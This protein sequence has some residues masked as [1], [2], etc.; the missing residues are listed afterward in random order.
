MATRRRRPC[1]H[2]KL[3]NK[4]RG[5]RCRKVSR[6]RRRRR[7]KHTEDE[8]VS[9][10]RRRRRSRKSK[11]CKARFPSSL[12]NLM[13]RSLKERKAFLKLKKK[14]TDLKT[15]LS[16]ETDAVKQAAINVELVK[17][18]LDVE[19]VSKKLTELADKYTKKLAEFS[20]K[21]AVN[22]ALAADEDAKLSA[23]FAKLK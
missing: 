16:A 11:K 15:K 5:R 6:R 2:G 22:A 20:S 4:T 3:K 1:K 9:K 13:S 17:L 18:D 14:Q 12:S 10:K 21:S 23:K 19:K 7:R 8:G